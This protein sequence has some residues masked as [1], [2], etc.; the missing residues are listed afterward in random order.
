M[1]GE[2]SELIH[3]GE[4]IYKL[5]KKQKHVSEGAGREGGDFRRGSF[6]D[7]KRAACMNILDPCKDCKSPFL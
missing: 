4:T 5:R 1:N 6:Q 3:I 7:R 2:K